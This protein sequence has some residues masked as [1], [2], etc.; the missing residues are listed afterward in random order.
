MNANIEQ[1]IRSLAKED[2]QK[3]RSHHSDKVN[4]EVFME[5]SVD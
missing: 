3:R 1:C 2:I 4:L 5:C